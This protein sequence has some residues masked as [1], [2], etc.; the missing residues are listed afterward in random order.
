MDDKLNVSKAAGA[1]SLLTAGLGDELCDGCGGDL[2]DAFC[3][4]C[5]VHAPRVWLQRIVD[6][7]YRTDSERRAAK[8][9]MEILP[10]VTPN[11]IYTSFYLEAIWIG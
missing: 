8:F 7:G 2:G 10:P 9:L 4:S 5:L 11:V 6:D 3:A 1:Q